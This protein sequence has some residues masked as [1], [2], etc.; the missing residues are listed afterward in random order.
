MGIIIDKKGCRSKKSN[1]KF[2]IIP[3]SMKKL[4]L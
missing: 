1:E 3:N 2:N 4:K